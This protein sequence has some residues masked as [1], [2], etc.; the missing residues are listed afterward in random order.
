M[1]EPE[2][3]VI[4]E[5]GRLGGRVDSELTDLLFLESAL[6]DQ[7]VETVCLPYRPD[8]PVATPNYLRSF[9]LLVPAYQV[10]RALKIVVEA[11][12]RSTDE[13]FE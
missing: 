2:W 9:Q 8:N 1:T 4:V 7:G 3:T 6:R 11:L 12:G 10:A 13:T 5:T